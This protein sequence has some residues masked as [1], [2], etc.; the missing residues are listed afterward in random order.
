MLVIAATCSMLAYPMHANAQSPSDRQIF[1]DAARAGWRFANRNYVPSTGLTKPFD[2]YSIATMWDIASGIAALFCAY[3]LGFI[4]LG[5][6][7]QRMSTAL[8]TLNRLPLFEQTSFNKEYV[9]DSGRMIGLERSVSTRGFGI[10]AI[11]TGRLLL[12]LRIVAN[13]H[14]QHAAHANA[15]VRRIDFTKLLDDGYLHGMQLS[16]RSGR[17]RTFQEGRIGYEQYAAKGYDVWGLNVKNALDHTRH[18]RDVEVS[19][20]TLPADK[21]GNDRLTSEPFVLLGLEA[22]LT[23]PLRSV[24]EGVLRAQE[25]RYR[26]T[27]VLTMVS[28]DAINIPPDYFFY[29][30][31]Y[32]RHGPWTLD[33]QR[34][35]AKVDRP[36]WRS[37]KAAFGWFALMPDG[38]TRMAVDTIRARARV[39]NVWGSGVF[40]D[41]RPTANANIN[42]A[43]VVMTAAVYHLR[44][45]PLLRPQV[46]SITLP[47]R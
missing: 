17:V 10:S 4:G 23:A 18:A 21:R 32:S 30:T 45:T 7:N 19:G 29:Y 39:G 33:V 36:R 6:Y 44:G 28:E 12:W 2:T 13:N 42:T 3:E 25:A 31:V 11:D 20:Q 35:R 8:N 34:P 5:E 38:Y 9:V 14:P 15:I 41:G 37:T 16:R 40:E 27:R 47:A 22:G 26:S 46:R 1:L 43:A 24:A